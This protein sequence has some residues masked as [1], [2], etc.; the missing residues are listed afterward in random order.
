MK[1][2]ILEASNVIELNDILKKES[3]NW[4]PICITPVNYVDTSG[5]LFDANKNPKRYFYFLITLEWR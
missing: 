5:L 1:Y 4:K 2:K 3:R